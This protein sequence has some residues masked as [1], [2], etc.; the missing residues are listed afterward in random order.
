M[1][2]QSMLNTPAVIAIGTSVPPHRISQERHYSIL[3]SANGMSREEKLQ[4]RK[5][6]Q[7]SG[8]QSRHSVLSEFGEADSHENILFHPGNHHAPIPVSK[9]MDLY[10]LYAADLCLEAV[11][12]C[13]SKTP[14]VTPSSITHMITFSC[15]GMHAPGLDIQLI[16]KAGLNRNV[17][18]TCINFMG[19]YAGINALKVAYHICRS[20]PEAIVLLA[21]V[22]LCTLH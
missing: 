9:R 5:I 6:Y 11:K 10:E 12:N 17:E 22:E 8:I 3:E 19:C 1:S 2:E 4:L 13:L 15:T 7:H 16:E 20:E 18:R 14:A 21:G